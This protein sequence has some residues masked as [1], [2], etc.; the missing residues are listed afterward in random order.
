M[1]KTKETKEIMNC[2]HRWYWFYSMYCWIYDCC[3]Y[4]Y[5]SSSLNL[6]LDIHYRRRTAFTTIQLLPL[7]L[8]HCTC[9]FLVLQWTFFFLI[10]NSRT[11]ICFSLQL[12]IE[13]LHFALRCCSQ[14][15]CLLVIQRCGD[16]AAM[17]YCY[18][19]EM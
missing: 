7:L 5:A 3:Y 12:S 14:R 11:S 10:W 2:L 8:V 6:Y 4:W 18:T 16:Y 1:R 9:A 19:M 15:C 17:L 13:I